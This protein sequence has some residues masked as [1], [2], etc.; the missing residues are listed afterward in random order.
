MFPGAITSAKRMAFRMEWLIY[1]T[2]QTSN[3][4]WTQVGQLLNNCGI[5][6]QIGAYG[7]A[8]N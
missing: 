4:I 3:G 6:F 2:M 5:D 1:V 7:A 8:V